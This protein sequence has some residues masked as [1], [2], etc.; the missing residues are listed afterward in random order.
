MCSIYEEVAAYAQAIPG[1]CAPKVTW[2]PTWTF[3][4]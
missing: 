4:D 1:G 3:I 2:Q